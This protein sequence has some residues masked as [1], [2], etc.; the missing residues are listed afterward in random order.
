[1]WFSAGENYVFQPLFVNF[2]LEILGI[3]LGTTDNNK[4]CFSNFFVKGN[5][6]SDFTILKQ[7][8]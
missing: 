4:I 8:A 7:T 6:V 5:H 2:L 3:F 1:M